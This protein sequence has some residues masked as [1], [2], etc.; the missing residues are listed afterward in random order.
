MIQKY[1][2]D[3]DGQPE[4]CDD[5]IEWGLWMRSEKRVIGH[6]MIGS[7]L[8]STVFLGIDHYFGDSALEHVPILFETMVFGGEHDQYCR[9]YATK[10]K[11]ISGHARARSMVI[12]G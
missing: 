2:L 8:V 5:I 12:G 11:A 6:D 10:T 3:A 9:R 4:P 7:V 1:I